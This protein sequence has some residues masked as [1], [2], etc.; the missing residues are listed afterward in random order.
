MSQASSTGLTEGLL[1]TPS[2]SLSASLVE[3]IARKHFAVDGKACLL[4]GER[5]QNFRLSTDSG[6]DYIVKVTNPAE[7]PVVTDFQT[8]ALLHIE[9]SNPTLPVPRL[10]RAR[11]DKPDFTLKG[12]D[13]RPMI[14]RLLTLLPGMPL[15]KAIHSKGQRRALGI[16][17]A[18][19][20]LALKDFSHPAA[21]HFLQ[22][23]IKH[24]AGLRPLLHHIENPEQRHLAEHF[25]DR[26]DEHAA[27][28][29]PHLRRQIVHNDL[30]PYNVLVAAND[31]ERVTGI[32]D[33]GDMVETPLINDVAI[34]ASYQISLDGN[35][36]EEIV[37]FVSAYNLVCPL[38]PLEIGLLPDLIA[39][40]MVT[41]VAITN[42]RALR[43]PENR[44]YILR[45]S[46][47][48]WNGLAR[49]AELD[50]NAALDR[51]AAA[52]ERN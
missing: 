23:D 30:N 33:F 6:T 9:H 36:V 43:Y 37:D 11:D 40:R 2:P 41:T 48:A 16:A 35:P 31:Y 5:D 15:Y 4:T 17:L 8:Q 27:P 22:W 18:R 25:L 52:C 46:P 45:N 21:G 34:A 14:I 19:L 39:A 26:F 28:A 20:G 49:F 24:A 3:Q 10:L 32:F 38:E 12:E 47:A 51:L 13:G 29:M 44:T 7:D 50:W 1:A 42:W